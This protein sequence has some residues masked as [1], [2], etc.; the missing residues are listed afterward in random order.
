MVPA[1][2]KATGISGMML[3]SH[4]GTCELGLQLWGYVP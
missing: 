4:Q 1:P 2:G 3:S